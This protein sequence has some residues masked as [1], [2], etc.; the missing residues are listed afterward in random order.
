MQG[1]SSSYA[2]II[3]EANFRAGKEEDQKDNYRNGE[4][5]R[6]GCIWLLDNNSSISTYKDLLHYY[7]DYSIRS[8]GGPV[9][10]FNEQEH[11][12]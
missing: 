10:F 5:K 7:Y 12:T 3:F 11:N 1:L 4:L 9:T 2:P 6:L 8:Q